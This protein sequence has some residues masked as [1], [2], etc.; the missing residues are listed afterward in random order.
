MVGENWLKVAFAAMALGLGLY[1]IPLGM[2][3]NPALIALADTPGLALLAALKVGLG[4]ALVSF[5]VIAPK[6]LWLKAVL[7]IAGLGALFV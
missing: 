3:A 1:L 4:L 2:I 7:V 6:A 5:G